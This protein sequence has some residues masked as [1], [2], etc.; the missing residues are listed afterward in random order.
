M[1]AG[2]GFSDGRA[3]LDSGLD[4]GPFSG[5]LGPGKSSK[6]AGRCST[7]NGGLA[8]RR[9]AH[10]LRRRQSFGPNNCRVWWDGRTVDASEVIAR[11]IRPV[12]LGGGSGVER[13]SVRR[14]QERTV[15][16]ALRKSR[17]TIGRNGVTG[18][19]TIATEDCL[20][21][22]AQRQALLAMV[23]DRSG[24]GLRSIKT[25][26]GARLVDGR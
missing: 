7:P 25:R 14:R 19:A 11:T 4:E 20:R 13:H 26:R 22:P 24:S 12:R 1:Q 23:K 17:P 2:A 16:N 21:R 10:D 18:A 6:M 15:W 8:Q 9:F 3:G 5:Y